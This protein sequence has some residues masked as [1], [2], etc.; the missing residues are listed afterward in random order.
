[1]EEENQRKPSRETVKE[2]GAIDNHSA[3]QIMTV[4][5]CFCHQHFSHRLWHFFGK[6]HKSKYLKNMC[7]TTLQCFLQN[8]A[9]INNPIDGYKKAALWQ[10]STSQKLVSGNWICSQILWKVKFS[11]PFCGGEWTN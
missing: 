7:Q 2:K 9:D 11:H 3:N 4:N 10:K 5:C 6:R 8:M 1:M